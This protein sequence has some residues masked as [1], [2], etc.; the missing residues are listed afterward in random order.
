MLPS[1]LS[2]VLASEMIKASARTE[3]KKQISPQSTQR[4]QSFF[5]VKTK[6]ANPIMHI[7]SSFS[8]DPPGSKTRG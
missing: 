5:F 1:L 2:F 4:S 7:D 8:F 3:R 6:N